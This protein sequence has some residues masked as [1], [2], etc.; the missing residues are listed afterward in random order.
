MYD[1]NDD[2]DP[3]A[4]LLSYA[5]WIIY[6]VAT[7]STGHSK[8]LQKEW[9]TVS[10]DQL[11]PFRYG[12]NTAMAYHFYADPQKIPNSDAARHKAL[13]Q[14]SAAMNTLLSGGIGLLNEEIRNQLDPTIRAASTG[15][16]SVPSVI[17]D[18]NTF[19]T[20]DSN[21]KLP[22]SVLGW[23]RCGNYLA[24]HINKPPTSSKPTSQPKPKPSRSHQQSKPSITARETID[25]TV[26]KRKP[27]NSPS[28]PTEPKK[29]RV[30]IKPTTGPSMPDKPTITDSIIPRKNPPSIAKSPP[31]D[32]S[33]LESP[34]ISLKRTSTILWTPPDHVENGPP[35]FMRLVP[36]LYVKS[37]RVTR[38]RFNKWEKTVTPHTNL[39]A[40]YIKDVKAHAENNQLDP[41]EPIYPVESDSY[42]CFMH[43]KF[44]DLYRASSKGKLDPIDIEHAAN[45]CTKVAGVQDKLIVKHQKYFGATN[46]ALSVMQINPADESKYI[47]A[48][49]HRDMLQKDLDDLR[50]SWNTKPRAK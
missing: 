31:S 34:P 17:R 43:P 6:L 29:L 28:T 7:V 23:M 12:I 21:A 49:R 32:E 8:F 36:Y 42:L 38:S 48:Y 46:K 20:G 45:F 47:F 2:A 18:L 4:P 41:E 13:T 5:T 15:T 27:S 14:V 16:A 25:L 40:N 50:E 35:G 22:D 26:S 19:I 24:E 30:L 3:R 10:K 1:T 39:F 11:Q 44:D 37:D 33:T 9:M